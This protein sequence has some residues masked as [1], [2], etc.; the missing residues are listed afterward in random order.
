M[1]MKITTLIFFLFLSIPLTVFAGEE[2]STSEIEQLEKGEMVKK[3]VW[4]EGYIWPEV[5][6][7][8]LLNH[9]PLDNLNVFMDFESQKK[10]VPDMLESKVI[11][12]ISPN[13]MHVYFEMEMPWPVKKTTHVT[14]NVI[15]KEQNG[16]YTLTWNL[17]EG[18]MLKATDGHISFS[19]Y[20]GKTLLTYVSLIVPNSSLAGMFKNRVAEDVEKSVKT[21]TK[22]LGKTLGKSNSGYST[23]KNEMNQKNL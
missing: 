22:H 21:I 5:T 23:S 11:K 18:K 15:T 14:N 2:L 6:V 3:V 17:V 1:S 16:T 12:K 19:P 9:S 20:K 10:Y 13:Q 7:V 8:T 4:K